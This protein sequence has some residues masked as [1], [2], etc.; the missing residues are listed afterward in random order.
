[1]Y[2]VRLTKHISDFCRKNVQQYYW[3][4]G[5]HLPKYE[6]CG[7]HGKYTMHICC[8]KDPGHHGL[9]HITVR[10]LYTW[11]VETLGD[12]AVA[13]MVVAY[14]LARGETTMQTLMHSTN[15]DMS[16]VCKRATFLGGTVC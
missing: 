10:E 9:F 6:S 13:S 2:Q 1:M 5:T 8:C 4:N 16:V 12:R 14:L 3:S 11:M 7:T 15:I